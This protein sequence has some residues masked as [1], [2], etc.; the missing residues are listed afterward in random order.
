MANEWDDR[1]VSRWRGDV[2]PERLYGL[3]R[4]IVRRIEPLNG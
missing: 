1:A 3:R 2:P 4:S